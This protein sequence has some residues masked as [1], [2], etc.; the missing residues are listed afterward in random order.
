M[1]TWR[2]ILSPDTCAGTVAL[3]YKCGFRRAR[4][5]VCKLIAG[6]PITARVNC[7]I[8]KQL[9]CTPLCVFVIVI[10]AQ[11]YR[12]VSIVIYCTGHVWVFQIFNIIKA[13]LV[14][15]KGIKY[16]YKCAKSHIVTSLLSCICICISD[17]LIYA[18][19]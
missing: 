1:Y 3:R 7:Y 4:W 9:I 16:R 12:L 15:K 8:T 14:N 19:I 17:Q 18:L 6:T 2:E 11:T 13:F 5:Q 10:I